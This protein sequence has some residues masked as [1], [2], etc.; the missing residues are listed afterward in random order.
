MRDGRG[1]VVTVRDGQFRRTKRT[2]HEAGRAARTVGTTFPAPEWRDAVL[3]LAQR[4][5]CRPGDVMVY[6]VSLLMAGVESGEVE[7][8]AGEV[9]WWMR[10]GEGFRLPWEP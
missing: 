5:G 8:P 9:T 2:P 7:R 4:W 6:A 1:R 10:T 3:A